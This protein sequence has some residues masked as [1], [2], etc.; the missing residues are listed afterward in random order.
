MEKITIGSE[1]I[2]WAVGGGNGGWCWAAH[3]NILEER[4]NYKKQVFKKY[5]S[6]I[7]YKV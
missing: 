2:G 7:R 3:I 1:I 4:G 5:N 6:K